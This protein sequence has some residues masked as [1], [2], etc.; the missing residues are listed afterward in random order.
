VK[1]AVMTVRIPD[2]SVDRHRAALD[3]AKVALLSGLRALGHDAVETHEMWLKDRVNIVLNASMLG[4]RGFTKPRPPLPEDA[5]LYNFE[6]MG[7]PLIKNMLPLYRGR[8]V[9]ESFPEQMGVWQDQYGIVPSFAPLGWAPE[10]ETVR[11]IPDSEKNLDVLFCG[12]ISDRRREVL[13][14]LLGALDDDGL[15]V[16]IRTADQPS[17][18]A[19]YDALCGEA[20]IVLNLRYVDEYPVPVVR[21]VHALSNRCLLLTEMGLC[22]AGLRGGYLSESVDRL[23][24]TTRLWAKQPAKV[25]ERIAEVGQLAIRNCPMAENLHQPIAEL[26]LWGGD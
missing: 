14:P 2:P 16:G 13:K 20:K 4:W 1:F 3:P 5:I 23:A 7:S 26:D 18:G 8:R 19:D 24:E 25:R 12:S 21:A 15:T 6:S 11:H 17:Y 10:L 22:V 9:W